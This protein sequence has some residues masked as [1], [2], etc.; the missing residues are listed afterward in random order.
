M[1]GRGMA[2]VRR[3]VLMLVPG[4]AGLV[5]TVGIATGHLAALSELDAKRFLLFIGVELLAVG[6]SRLGYEQLVLG[7][8]TTI[9][10]PDALGFVRPLVRNIIPL[11]FALATMLGVVVGGRVGFGVLV[12]APFDVLSSVVA[13]FEL[14]RRK[15][16][17][18]IAFSWLNYPLFLVFLVVPGLRVN[19]SKVGQIVAAFCA[20]SVLRGLIA[21]VLVMRHQKR[22]RMYE[23]APVTFSEIAGAGVTTLAMNVIQRVDSLALLVFKTRFSLASVTSYLIATRLLDATYTVTAVVNGLRQVAE[24][25]RAAV[26]RWTDRK[27]VL[28]SLA[29]FAVWL[30]GALVLALFKWS[31]AR[32]NALNLL[33]AALGSALYLAVLRLI[34]RELGALR[35]LALGRR[36][37]RYALVAIGFSIVAVLLR[38]PAL[39]LLPAIVNGVA[40][41]RALSHI[42]TSDEKVS[43]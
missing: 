41:A 11:S 19:G 3:A 37:G 42:P 17:T 30:V 16:L 36:F 14:A 24:G 23:S 18:T 28:G 40:A 27:V 21:I 33:L 7:R 32:H 8:A 39:M 12:A 5:A 6:A 9:E 29:W 4:A 25:G 2:D 22:H 31:D 43:T 1:A 10:H 34:V 15:F 20:T 35:G 26:I 13:S 38:N